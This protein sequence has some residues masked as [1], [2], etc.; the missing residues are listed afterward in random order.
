MLP[1]PPIFFW[2]TRLSFPPR[3]R[4]YFWL[5]SASIQDRQC[6]VAASAN[7]VTGSIV[8]LAVMHFATY[9]GFTQTL[10]YNHSDTP[11]FK[12]PFVRQ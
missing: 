10:D 4:A 3:A 2:L 8:G 6:A 7:P 5:G 9:S 12:I 11:P 1:R